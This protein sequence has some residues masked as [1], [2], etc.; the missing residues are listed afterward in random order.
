LAID[1]VRFRGIVNGSW[2]Y[3]LRLRPQFAFL[4]YVVDTRK[5]RLQTTEQIVMGVL[6]DNGVNAEW[7]GTRELDVR[8]YT[9]QYRETSRAFVSRLLELE[10]VFYTF[11]DDGRLVMAD[12]S[13]SSGEVEGHPVVTLIETGD[14]MSWGERGLSAI[15]KGARVQSG[16]ATVNDHNWKKPQ[17]PLIA[18]RAADRDSDLEVYDYPVGYRRPEQGQRLAQTKLD[19]LRVGARYVECT[20]NVPG[21]RP[22]THFTFAGT[23][24][25][26]LGFAGRYLLT[27]VRHTFR[28]H[29]LGASPKDG[30]FYANESRAIPSDVTY[31]PAWTTPHPEV[32]GSHTAMVR[33][34]AG[35][36]IHTDSYGR[37]R[38][39]FHWDREAKATDE[40]PGGFG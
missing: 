19:A 10:G 27:G 4:D 23:T 15:A 17:L 26:A 35:E 18:S 39:Q 40:D 12:R 37:F 2:R 31:R 7:R 9:V 34:P 3:E 22:G 21:F 14:G 30:S 6:S 13:Q 5:F 16:A 33:G 24:V 8:K 20:G 11:E 29:R 36:E 1:A 28:D 32:A 38:A 25:G